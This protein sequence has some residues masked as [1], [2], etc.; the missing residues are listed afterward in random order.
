[1]L[2]RSPALHLHIPVIYAT[3]PSGRIALDT[4]L[5]P[6]VWDLRLLAEGHTGQPWGTQNRFRSGPGSEPPTLV[7]PELRRGR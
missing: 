4:L 5:A 7:A 1:M 3:Q 6:D 2:T